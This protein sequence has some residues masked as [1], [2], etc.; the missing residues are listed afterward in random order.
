MVRSDIFLKVV[1][2]HDERE[3]VE[4]LA[5]ELCRRLQKLYGVRTAEVANVV[6]HGGGRAED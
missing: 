6:S 2:E 4:K 1:V 5:D 3:R